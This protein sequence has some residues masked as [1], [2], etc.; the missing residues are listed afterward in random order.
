MTTLDPCANAPPTPPEEPP[1]F[2]DKKPRRRVEPTG[3]SKGGGLTRL[4][5]LEEQ[6]SSTEEQTEE[7]SGRLR[8]RT[9]PR[10]PY[11]AG[12]PDY[13]SR[14]QKEEWLSRWKMEVG[15]TEIIICL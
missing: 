1:P 5:D 7:Q 9:T 11:Q 8:R 3:R 6:D 13:V 10:V 14:R 12:D 4:Y 2:P 15:P